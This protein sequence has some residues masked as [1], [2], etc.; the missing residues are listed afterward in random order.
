MLSL[1]V[2]AIVLGACVA[3]AGAASD[4][5]AQELFYKGKRLTVLINFAAGGPADIEGRIFAKYL[6]KHIDGSP[7]LVVQNM[8]GAGGSISATTSLSPVSPARRSTSCGPMCRP[9][10]RSRPTS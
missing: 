8:D 4:G 6:V 7:T 1:R 10:S 9:A 3:F 2:Q 5:R